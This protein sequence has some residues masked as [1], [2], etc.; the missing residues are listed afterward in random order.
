M[1]KRIGAKIKTLA[2][3][4]CW[5][6][7]IACIITGIVFMTPDVHLILAGILIAVVGSLLSWIGSFVLYGFGQLV[8]NSDIIANR[9]SHN[10]VDSID[11]S[12]S[13]PH[14]SSN[15]MRSVK[16]KTGKCE[17]CGTDNVDVINCKIVDDM[18]TRYR[19]LC[20]NCQSKYNATPTK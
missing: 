12:D 2:E 1:F 14:F 17:M 6:G 3:V 10:D 16:I 13:L 8:E 19:K 7:I 11:S 4:M 18:G 15:N 9:N 5:V 20:S